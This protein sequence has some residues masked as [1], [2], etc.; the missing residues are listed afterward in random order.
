V[1]ATPTVLSV[2]TP[3]VVGA[4]VELCIVVLAAVV[5][6]TAAVL[7]PDVPVVI[8]AVVDGAKVVLCSV[9]PKDTLLVV[10]TPVVGAAVVV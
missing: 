9:A 2:V 7:T 1:L 8:A 6:G 10:T 5:L 3:A 4:T